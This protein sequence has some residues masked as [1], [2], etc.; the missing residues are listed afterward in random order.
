MVSRGYR[1]RTLCPLASVIVLTLSY[2]AGAELVC[3]WHFNDFVVD[4]IA[5]VANHGE[6][7]IDMSG[8]E[9]TVDVFGGTDLNGLFDDPAGTA[10]GIRGSAGNGSWVELQ[11]AS[12][13]PVEFSFAYRVT[14]TGFDENLIQ[15]WEGR[16]WE[17]LAG[18][19]GSSAATSAGVEWERMEVLLPRSSN[20]MRLR[21]VVDGA[22]GANG[23]IRFDNMQVVSV[24]SPGGLVLGATGG[25]LGLSCRRRRDRQP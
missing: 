11:F 13:L 2:S 22:D 19:G 7:L 21:L 23:T 1:D 9:G 4:E 3:G 20:D 17:T 14:E 8:V 5:L 24:P 15:L 18:F 16:S 25:V 10:L 6:G 12:V